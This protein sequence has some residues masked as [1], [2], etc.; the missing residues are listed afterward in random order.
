MTKETLEALLDASYGAAKCAD[1]ILLAELIPALET[2]L[3][4]L[5]PNMGAGQLAQLQRKA[6]R[7]AVCVSA[8]G[9]GIRSAI[10]RLEDVRRAVSGLAAYDN[11]G[12]RLN[13]ALPEGRSRRF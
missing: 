3:A 8:M 11:K 10:R 1:F 12:Q 7:N 6:D 2:A 13:L 4:D 5:A 9:R